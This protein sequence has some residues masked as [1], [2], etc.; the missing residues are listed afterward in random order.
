MMRKARR[1]TDSV[2]QPTKNK[3]RSFRLDITAKTR[4]TIIEAGNE[5]I[6]INHKPVLS[7]SSS[8]NVTKTSNAT[9]HTDETI[10]KANFIRYGFCSRCLEIFSIFSGSL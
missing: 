5:A 2:K 10:S 6:K 7:V 3:I 1:L 9:N 4:K 8:V